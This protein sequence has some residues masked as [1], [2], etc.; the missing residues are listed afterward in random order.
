M[1]LN[2]VGSKNLPVADLTSSHVVS[3]V[4][5]SISQYTY[6]YEYVYPVKLHPYTYIWQ[7]FQ[8]WDGPFNPGLVATESIL[9]LASVNQNNNKPFFKG[10]SGVQLRYRIASQ[11][12][13]SNV[14]QYEQQQLFRERGV[15]LLWSIPSIFIKYCK[16]VNIYEHSW[17][18]DTVK[19]TLRYCELFGV[20]GLSTHAERME[21]S[22][23]KT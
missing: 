10:R 8:R 17:L 5:L 4:T 13:A 12:T 23:P 9:S 18:L 14:K 1:N 16:I 2:R 3:A 15:N 21:T 7:L 22:T 20:S 6:A 19:D 11:Y